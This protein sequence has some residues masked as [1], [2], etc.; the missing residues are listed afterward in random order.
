MKILAL[1]GSYRRNGN[2]DILAKEA[3][4]GAEEA[5]AEVELLHLTD[6]KIEA[7]QGFGLCLF[8]KE[9]C[10]I[11]DDVKEIWSKIEA[12]DGSPERALLFPRIDCRPEAT[13]R[14]RMGPGPPG[15]LSG[16]VRVGPGP[17]RD[18]GMDP[19][20]DA[21]AEH[22]LRHPRVRRHPPGDLQC[23]GAGRSRPR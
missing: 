17:L 11:E 12:A 21:S 13:P 9:G 19:L 5:G 16:Q 10:H 22:L 18:P 3:L 14:S 4:M 2:S 6:Y 15:H 23:P 20:C 1:V 7:C 8:R